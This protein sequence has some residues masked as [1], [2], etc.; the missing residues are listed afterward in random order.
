M[1]KVLK[2]ILSYVGFALL[3]A[4]IIFAFF[5]PAII[6]TIKENNKIMTVQQT[7]Q[8]IAWNINYVNKSK[9]IVSID[10]NF[11]ENERESK[12]WEIL[13]IRHG[14][15]SVYV[16]HDYI[17]SGEPIGNNW[18][19]ITV[20]EKIYNGWDNTEVFEHIRY[21][22]EAELLFTLPDQ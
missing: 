2:E 18:Y 1:N 15:S 16:T 10:A 7:M 12:Y 4:L 11:T 17:L 14:D 19:K 3:I 21:T 22:Y 8:D 9:E 20:T 6:N 5:A 13:S